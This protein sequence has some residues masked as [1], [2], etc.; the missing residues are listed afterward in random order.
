MMFQDCRVGDTIYIFDRSTICLT[1]KNV[2]RVSAPYPDRSNIVVD[3]SVDKF[4]TY[5]FKASDKIGYCGEFAI[6][7]DKSVL[8]RVVE[9]QMASKERQ[10]SKLK[11]II[12]QLNKE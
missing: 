10:V 12:E 3:V 1:T 8:M 2:V 5:V 6:S 7:V 11:E 9:A 4:T